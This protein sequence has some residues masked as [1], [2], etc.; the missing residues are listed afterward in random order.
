MNDERRNTDSQRDNT[1]V[2]TLR[3]GALKLSIFRNRGERGDYYSMVPGRVYTDDAGTVRETKSLSGSDPLRMA[4]LL[5]RGYDRV[6]EFKAAM[7]Q[8]QGRERGRGRRRA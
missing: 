3:D 8:D 2:E 6:G 4:N 7:K 5:T 1:P